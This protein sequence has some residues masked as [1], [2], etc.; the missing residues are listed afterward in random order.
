MKL[1][2][3][4][5]A[6]LTVLLTVSFSFIIS[7]SNQDD[8]I[9]NS[10]IEKTIEFKF[11]F[12]N[13]SGKIHDNIPPEVLNLMAQKLKEENED[14]K[15]SQLKKSYDFNTGDLT[16]E[17]KDSKLYAEIK[18]NSVQT[19]SVVYQYRAHVAKLGWLP[20]QNMGQVAGT[21]GQSRRMEA[22]E[23][24]NIGPILYVGRANVAG[25]GWLQPSYLLG[26]TG[27]SRQMEAVQIYLFGFYYRAHVANIGW[28]PWQTAYGIAGTT[29]QNRRM[30]AFQAMNIAF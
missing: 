27:Q 29:G 8:I 30:E 14:L 16:I 20:W 23:W 6:I 15:L 3:K 10:E 17:A 22:L 21:T 26:T 9:G 24:R 5:Y 4:K 18:N 12:D 1:T 28:L 19:K 11:A 2:I 13:N 25:I 7:C